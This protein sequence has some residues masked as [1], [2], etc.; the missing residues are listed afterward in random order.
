MKKIKVLTVFILLLLLASCMDSSKL[1]PEV[2]QFCQD[3]SVLSYRITTFSSNL[4]NVNTSR[5]VEGGPYKRLIARN[6]KSGV[7]EIVADERNPILKYE[8]NHPDANKNG[9]VAYP[10]IYVD[11]EKRDQIF[12]ERAYDTVWSN[13]PVGKDFFL[14][15]P[16][17]ELCFQK[18]P[19]LK[20]DFNFKEYLGR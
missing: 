16:R 20:N 7:C 8:P 2:D 9:Y 17:A 11:E 13:A 3:L 18:Y 14:R 6:C 4:A 10:L 15:D 19:I 5:T 12:W 1:S